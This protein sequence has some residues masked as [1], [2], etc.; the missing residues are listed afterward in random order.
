MAV[1]ASVGLLHGGDLVVCREK[2]GDMIDVELARELGVKVQEGPMAMMLPQDKQAAIIRGG[3][4]NL[5]NVLLNMIVYLRAI[6]FQLSHLQDVTE[7]T[8]GIEE[9]IDKLRKDL[10]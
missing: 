3:L 1:L 4:D 7:M 8:E 5:T 6:E 9:E 2:E 10:T